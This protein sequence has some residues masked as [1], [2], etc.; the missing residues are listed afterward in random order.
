MIMSRLPAGRTFS[1]ESCGVGHDERG[2]I[3][4]GNF[5]HAVL[6]DRNGTMVLGRVL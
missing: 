1:K 3:T 2:N 5:S 6:R 4:D